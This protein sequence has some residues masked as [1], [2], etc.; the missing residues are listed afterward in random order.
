[1]QKSDK[2]ILVI[3]DIQAPFMHKDTLAFL[4]AVKKKYKP[5]HVVNIGDL[6]DSYCLSAWAKS[7]DAIS[8][9]EEIRRLLEFVKDLVKLFPKADILTS[10]HGDR[11]ERAAIRAGI[12]SH[13]IKDF[14]EWMG[15]PKTWKLHEE[16]EIDGILF[17]H[18]ED[19]SGQQASINRVLHY[20]KS[21]VA[22]HLH[23]LSE[24]RYF[25]NRENLLFGMSV[26]CLIDRKALAFTYAKK[27]MKKPILSVGFI[28][29]GVP[30]IIPM[31]L[32]KDGRWIGQL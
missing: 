15:L 9:R 26:G 25:A 32:N 11:L 13:F 1:M 29:K 10:N 5:T 24:V 21:T 28:D 16:L 23:T 17:V 18:G 31:L 19:A 3:S 12:P 8:G 27:Q 22:G 30:M 2:K 7:P 6:S 20:G 14:N 4:A